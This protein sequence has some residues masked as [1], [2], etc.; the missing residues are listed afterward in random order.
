M[1][2]GSQIA[3]AGV[4]RHAHAS[5]Q[6]F[7]RPHV[8]GGPRVLVVDSSRTRYRS[9]PRQDS[10][11]EPRLQR[12]PAV[13]KR[14]G[15]RNFSSMMPANVRIAPERPMTRSHRSVTTVLT[16]FAANTLG[17]L[18]IRTCAVPKDRRSGGRPSRFSFGAMMLP[19]FSCADPDNPS[20]LPIKIGAGVV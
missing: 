11:D 2:C 13:E 9:P 3:A 4:D 5:A 1:S 17:R 15:K 19:I 7:E 16:C 12:K 18:A 10:G 6:S 20:F 8:I 14:F